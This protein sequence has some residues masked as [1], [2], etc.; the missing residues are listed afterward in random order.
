[1]V[2]SL[3]ILQINSLDSLILEMKK[4]ESLYYFRGMA[5][6]DWNIL[7]S[8]DRM[9]E[10]IKS[11][12]SNVLLSEQHQNGFLELKAQNLFVKQNEKEL[13][14]L[15]KKDESENLEIDESN[16][17]LIQVI[18]QHYG[19]P[20]RL[21]DWTKNWKKALF[22]CIEDSSQKEDF[23]L[24]CIKRNCIPNINKVLEDDEYLWPEDLYPK[25]SIISFYK[26]L[27]EGV[28][29]ID[30]PKFKRIVAQ[31]GVL[32]A[33]GVADYKNFENQIMGC[34]WINND[35]IL[36]IVLSKRLRNEV[37]SFLVEQNITTTSLYPIDF[38]D[39]KVTLDNDKIEEF[40]HDLYNR[41]I[42][43]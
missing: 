26:R 32:L 3:K 5:S 27:R 38:L 35:D 1:M 6:K 7:S 15:L 19:Y 20:T 30:E 43:I 28:Y 23:A 4:I 40:M 42:S 17:L 16:F 29:L 24:W 37:K 22:F 2:D 21:T 33:S 14:E 12:N 13:K 25:N 18:L 36:K 10:R 11:Q 31:E 39:Q 34:D 8:A 9:L 41:K